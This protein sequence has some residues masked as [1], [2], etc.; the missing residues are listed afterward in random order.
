MRFT[1]LILALCFGTALTFGQAPKAEK[2]ANKADQE[3]NKGNIGKSIVLYDKAIALDSLNKDYYYYR[4]LALKASGNFISAANDY[5]TFL[6]ARSVHPTAYYELAHIYL[7]NG[8]DYQALTTI[9][10]HIKQNGA[11]YTSLRLKAEALLLNDAFEEADLTIDQALEKNKQDENAFILRAHIALNKNDFHA[12]KRD[13]TDTKTLFGSS[14]HLNI[15][16]G[17]YLLKTGKIDKAIR[18]IKMS[19]YPK[20]QPFDAKA[21]HFLSNA[22]HAAGKLDSA[23]W[24]ADQAIERL[25]NANY[26]FDRGCYKA[27]NGDRDGGASDFSTAIQIDRYSVGAYN[28]R[29]FYVWFPTEQY[30]KAVEDLSK[31]ILIDS[32]NAFAYNNRS[33]AYFKLANFEQAFIDAFK[34]VELE[35][36]NPYVYKNLALMY[37]AIQED[38]EAKEM[39]SGALKLNYPVETDLEFKALLQKLG[40]L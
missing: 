12:A 34:S 22:Y 37:H 3:F 39:A 13:L 9:N 5:E 14:Q 18:K 33:Y 35:D 24:A 19:I 16:E 23:I 38:E 27:E 25:E 6:L 11:D 10:H 15:M 8:Q 4:G 28:N 36:K 17:Y 2:F 31:I 30:S 21:Y 20:H 32:T 1:W 40:L 29:T 26:F 7:N